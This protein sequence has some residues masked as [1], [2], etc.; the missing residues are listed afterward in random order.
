MRIKQ[1]IQIPIFGKGVHLVTALILLVCFS[2]GQATADSVSGN[3]DN[4]D[5]TDAIKFL[6]IALS[7]ERERLTGIS[8]DNLIRMSGIRLDFNSSEASKIGVNLKNKLKPTGERAINLINLTLGNINAG[9]S[10]IE[11][12]EF[13]SETLDHLF[14][15]DVGHQVKCLAEAI[16]FEARGE[17]V[18]GQYA[19]AEVILNRV[20][21]KQFPNSVCKVVSEGATKLHSCQFSYNCDGKPEFVNDS[22]SYK[23][24][25]KLANMFYSGTARLLTG[26]ATFYHTK[27]VNPSW[28][29]KLKKTRQIG[30]HIFYKIENRVAQK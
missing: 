13:S 3:K 22:K 25:L 19:V 1:E 23:R 14:L 5:D 30:G 28:T 7:N 21:A 18:V 20:D 16:Y 29:S 9:S 11:R 24:I 12:G 15:S 10:L 4:T 6:G 8:R 26:G 17:T 2:L 27:D